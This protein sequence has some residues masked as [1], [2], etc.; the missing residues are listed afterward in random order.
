[1]SVLLAALLAVSVQ[2]RPEF[3]GTADF[4]VGE[5]SEPAVVIALGAGNSDG[6]ERVVSRRSWRC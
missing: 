6:D 2:A 5:V 3:L 1:M 4:E